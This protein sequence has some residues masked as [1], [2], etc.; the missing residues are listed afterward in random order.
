MFLA[1]RCVPGFS[2]PLRQRMS[3]ELL[4]DAP[5]RQLARVAEQFG[6]C[7]RR[8]EQRAL[9]QEAQ[10]L[11]A[12][13][14]TCRRCADSVHDHLEEHGVS[15]D[16]VFEVDQLRDRT[17][18]IDALLNCLLSAQPARDIA[19]L[20]AEL[21]REPAPGAAVRAPVREPLL[22][23]RAQGRRAQRRDRRALH[24]PRP[25]R[26]PRDAARRGRRR[27]VLAGTTFV[28]FLVMALGL[29]AFWAG[30]WAGVNYAAS[31]VLIQLRTGRWRP[32]SRR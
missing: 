13:L 19:R 3:P 31:F 20:L 28:K 25:R 8:G 15:V 26:V 16:V 21:V 10:Y 4:R 18:R 6:E 29:S 27:A 1:A 23:A 14:D 30:F 32:S 24:H 22:A 7:A 11:R 17:H 9:L 12:L 2:G 5:F